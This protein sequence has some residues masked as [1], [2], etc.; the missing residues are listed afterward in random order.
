M[1]QIE[2]RCEFPNGIKTEWEPTGQ[3]ICEGD[4]RVTIAAMNYQ[5]K[6]EGSYLR[7]RSVPVRDLAD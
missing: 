5:S 7:Y 2:E 6:R 4:A 1:R 3:N